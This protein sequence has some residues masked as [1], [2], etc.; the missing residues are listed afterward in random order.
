MHVDAHMECLSATYGVRGKGGR[1]ADTL[2]THLRSSTCPPRRIRT[3]LMSSRL[4][5]SSTS[6]RDRRCTWTRLPGRVWCVRVS[7]RHTRQAGRH[8]ERQQSSRGPPPVTRVAAPP[9]HTITLARTTH[10]H[11]RH[12]C[13]MTLGA[14]LRVSRGD[15]VC[16]PPSPLS[17]SCVQQVQ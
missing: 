10:A 17:A 13:S 14:C 7:M 4:S 5:H 2:S 12:Q 8:E 6:P 3:S 1:A 9:P 16:W 11:A 15:R